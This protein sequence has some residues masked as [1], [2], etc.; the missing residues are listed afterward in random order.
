MVGGFPQKV[1]IIVTF[2]ILNSALT[3]L[4]ELTYDGVSVVRCHG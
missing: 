1:R 2:D 3:F 4:Q